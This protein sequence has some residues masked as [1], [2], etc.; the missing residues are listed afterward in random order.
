MLCELISDIPADHK[1]IIWAIFRRDIDMLETTFGD[2]AVSIH[3]GI[4]SKDR[5]IAVDRFQHDDSIRYF[6]GH[7]QSSAHGITLTAANYAIYYSLHY[8]F[9]FYQQSMDRIN[10]IG[11]EKPMTI[12]R[13]MV[14]NTI[15]QVICKAL[16][17]K[18]GMNDFLKNL[19]ENL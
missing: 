16:E 6:I 7:P 18:Q 19:R 4:S 13:L 12:Y 9:E 1:I 3:G 14:T 5:E 17:K 2:K 10:R 8:N 11:Q 15:D